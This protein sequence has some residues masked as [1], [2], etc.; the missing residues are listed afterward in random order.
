[1]ARFLVEAHHDKQTLACERV[2]KLFQATGSHYLT[3]AEWGCL[4]GQHTA[5]LMVDADTREEARAL[6]PP[7]F[8]GRAKVVA[9]TRFGP[10]DVDWIVLQHQVEEA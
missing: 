6:L 9:L 2:V 7:A 10:E 4:D 1:M 5:W 3:H 8:R